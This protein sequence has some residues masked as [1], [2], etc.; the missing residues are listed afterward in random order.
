MGN[1]LN[2]GGAILFKS[3]GSVTLRKCTFSDSTNKV[4]TCACPHSHAYARTRTAECPSKAK[5][6]GQD[7]AGG[8]LA[9]NLVHTAFLENCMFLRSASCSPQ[10][11]CRTSMSNG[12]AVYAEDTDYV[13]LRNCTF[14]NSTAR[15]FAHMHACM[16]AQKAQTHAQH[17]HALGDLPRAFALPEAESFILLCSMKAAPCQSFGRLQWNSRAAYSQTVLRRCDTHIN[18]HSSAHPCPPVFWLQHVIRCVC[19]D[20]CWSAIF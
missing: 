18:A 13:T 12:G 2:S 6:F 14:S 15:V 9:F 1:K 5:P 17:L 8:A 7:G 4:S 10:G 19:R 11:A 20:M 16:L 3:S